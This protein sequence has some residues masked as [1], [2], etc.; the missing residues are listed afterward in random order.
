VDELRLHVV[1]VLLG[2]GARLFGEDLPAQELR[3]VW[4]EASAN[5]LHQTYEVMRS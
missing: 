2:E 4:E 5:A 1:P 3:L